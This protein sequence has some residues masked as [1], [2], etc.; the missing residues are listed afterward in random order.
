MELASHRVYMA[1]TP[2]D[3]QHQE[4]CGSWVTVVDEAFLAAGDFPPLSEL[5]GEEQEIAEDT[6]L[7]QAAARSQYLQAADPDPRLVVAVAEVGGEITPRPDGQAGEYSLSRPVSLDEV[8]S[9]HVSEQLT[10]AT[11]PESPTAATESATLPD[12]LWFD[13]SE[14]EL[15]REFLG[16]NPDQ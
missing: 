5:H 4:F 8:V 10:A 11:A 1:L 15:V 14:L 16:V 9:F 3:L 13:V 12:L 7:Y 2:A 6:A